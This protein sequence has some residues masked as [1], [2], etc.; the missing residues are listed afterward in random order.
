MVSLRKVNT[1][2]EIYSPRQI[3]TQLKLIFLSFSSKLGK[4]FKLMKGD[5]SKYSGGQWVSHAQPINISVSKSMMRFMRN[6]LW[7]LNIFYPDKIL[8]ARQH[9]SPC[10]CIQGLNI[11]T[12][13]NMFVISRIELSVNTLFTMKP[14]SI[15]PL[16]HQQK[17]TSMNIFSISFP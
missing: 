1:H 16:T 4:Q 11:S 13:E 2:R 14:H 8:E 3:R 6:L 17:S 7:G 9:H 10:T 5:K 12:L 15:F